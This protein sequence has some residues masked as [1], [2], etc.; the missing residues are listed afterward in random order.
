MDDAIP[1]V[2]VFGIMLAWD[3]GAVLCMSESRVEIE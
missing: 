1:C 2:C 3:M